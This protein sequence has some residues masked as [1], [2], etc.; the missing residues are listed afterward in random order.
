MVVQ[1]WEKDKYNYDCDYLVLPEEVNLN[2]YY[3]ISKT[4]KIIYEAGQDIKY[5]VLDDDVEF[6]RRNAKYWTRISN[7][8]MSK[9]K[10]TQDDVLQMF[11]LYDNWLDDKEVTVC[12]C[13]LSENPPQDK[14]YSENSSL[15]S[16]FW[17]NG[18][19]FKDVLPEL[20]LT[21]IKVAE[22]VLFLLSLLNR[23]YGNRVS[24]E[25][26]VFNNSAHKKDMK[27][28]IWDEQTYENTLR[29]HKILESMFPGIF[30]ILYDEDGKRTSGGF[31]DFGKSK[32]LWSKA[33]KKRVDNDNPFLEYL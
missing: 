21:K 28:A 12:G 7:M 20:E 30:T 32:I 14:P 27:S 22:D 25:F 2:D 16:A 23:G 19:H 6:G 1:S 5:A 31:R 10:A 26:I 33:F 4:R 18:K 9:R 29:D 24:Q 11:D 17:I 15:S 3:C 13:G 8:E